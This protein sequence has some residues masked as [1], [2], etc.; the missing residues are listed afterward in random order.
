MPTTQCPVCSKA[1]IEPTWS[2]DRVWTRSSHRRDRNPAGQRLLVGSSRVLR[3][4]RKHRRATGVLRFRSASPG[5][6]TPRGG[7]RRFAQP[8]NRAPSKGDTKSAK[9]LEEPL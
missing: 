4:E 2:Q 8:G 5:G 3:V 1:D 6:T 7:N 9:N